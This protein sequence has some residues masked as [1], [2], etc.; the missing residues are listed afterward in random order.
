[1]ELR[2]ILSSGLM[3]MGDLNAGGGSGGLN[4]AGAIPGINMIILVKAI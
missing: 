4:P 1:M 2:R 3:T